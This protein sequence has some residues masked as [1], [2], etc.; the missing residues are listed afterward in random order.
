MKTPVFNIHLKPILILQD[1]SQAENGPNT[2]QKNTSIENPF[3][4]LALLHFHDGEGGIRKHPAQLCTVG[5]RA[6]WCHVKY[7]AAQGSPPYF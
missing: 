5:M 3:Q 6:E 4:K 2:D 7:R 1:K